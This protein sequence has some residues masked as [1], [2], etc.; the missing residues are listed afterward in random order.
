MQAEGGFGSRRILLVAFASGLSLD[1]NLTPTFTQPGLQ[2][3][4][5]QNPA[6]PQSRLVKS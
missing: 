6:L 5:C 1:L 2:F 4:F 3:E